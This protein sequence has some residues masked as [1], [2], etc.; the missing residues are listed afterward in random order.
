[1]LGVL[2]SSGMAAPAL[3]LSS[4]RPLAPAPTAEA[5]L[6][7]P[8]IQLR[9]GVPEG[10]GRKNA[11]WQPGNWFRDKQPLALGWGESSYF[12]FMGM[13]SEPTTT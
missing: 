8:G 11:A 13:P 7:R 2:A 5:Y 6:Q 12:R 1:M 9:E 3:V 4:N 10:I